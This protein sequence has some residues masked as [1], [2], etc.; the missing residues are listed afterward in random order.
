MTQLELIDGTRA[1]LTRRLKVSPAAI[2]PDTAIQDL[3]ADSLDMLMMAG[4]FEELFA[5]DISTKEIRDIRTFGDI[6]ARLSLKFGD[7][8]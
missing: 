5:V 6:I 7:A 8:A 3:G 4:E 2:T 1:V